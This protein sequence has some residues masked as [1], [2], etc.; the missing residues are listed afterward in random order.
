LSEIKKAES[1]IILAAKHA[2]RENESGVQS[3]KKEKGD[4]ET[5]RAMIP[6]WQSG[7]K[8]VLVVCKKTVTAMHWA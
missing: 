3:M 6:A 4:K 1:G 8:C 7:V 2:K 5:R